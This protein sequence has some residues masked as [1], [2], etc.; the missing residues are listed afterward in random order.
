[1]F[2]C[3]VL[4]FWWILLGK[5][6]L[7][8]WSFLLSYLGRRAVNVSPVFLYYG[9]GWTCVCYC[10]TALDVDVSWYGSG[11]GQRAVMLPCWFT[12]WRASCQSDCV[13]LGLLGLVW[14][15]YGWRL[16]TGHL[17]SVWY[18]INRMRVNEREREKGAGDPSVSPGPLYILSAFYIPL[19]VQTKFQAGFIPP[20][21]FLRLCTGLPN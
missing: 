2:F 8:T 17:L 16:E 12:V 7:K 5:W 18:R 1:M 19:K 20:T 4:F 6:N 3:F 9:K 14:E 21:L 13:W 10:W 11:V 15:G